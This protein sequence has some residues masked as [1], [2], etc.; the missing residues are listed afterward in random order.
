MTLDIYSSL[1]ED[2]LDEVADRLDAAAR[3]SA[4]YLRTKSPL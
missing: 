2:D 1:F 3:A 4:D